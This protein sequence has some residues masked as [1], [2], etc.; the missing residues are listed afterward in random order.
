MCP[1]VENRVW[2]EIGGEK[3][4]VRRE[5][6]LERMK[7]VSFSLSHYCFNHQRFFFMWGCGLWYIAIAFQMDNLEMFDIKTYKPKDNNSY[8]FSEHIFTHSSYIHLYNMCTLLNAVLTFP[9]GLFACT[10]DD[11]RSHHFMGNKW[12]NSGNSVRLYFFGLQNHCR[13]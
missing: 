10:Y 4:R 5:F 1:F 2:S 13:W 12:G 11:I 6:S 9:P 7:V 3:K 8:H